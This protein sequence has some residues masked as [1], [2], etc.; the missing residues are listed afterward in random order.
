MLTVAAIVIATSGYGRVAAAGDWRYTLRSPRALAQVERDVAA[1][2]SDVGQMTVGELVIARSR[3][4]PLLLVDVREVD[5][6]AVSRLSGAV[7]LDPGTSV[8]GAISMLSRSA[9]GRL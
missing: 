7:R 4:S 3:Q 6:F 9:R 5:E 8:S 1:R 2:Y